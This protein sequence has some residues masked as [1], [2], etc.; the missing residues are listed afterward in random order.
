MIKRQ[1]AAMAKK[2]KT[3][4]EQA[5]ELAETKRIQEAIFNLSKKSASS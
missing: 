5:N 4:Q 2:D 3:L 1:E